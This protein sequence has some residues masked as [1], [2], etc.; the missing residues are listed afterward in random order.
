MSVRA[1]KAFD[2]TMQCRGFQFEVG[3]TY[4]HDGKVVACESGF[5]ACENPLDVWSYYPLDSRYAV[6]DLSGAVSRHDDDSKIAAARITI[7]AEID[8]PQIISDG[9]AYLMGLCNDAFALKP[10]A[11]ASGYGSKLAA[12]GYG[13]KLAASGDYS[14][15]A[16]SG[17]RSQLAA[18]GDRSVCMSAGLG[19]T[20]RAGDGGA[21]ALTYH[22]GTRYRIAVAYVGEGGIEPHVDYRVTDSGSFI[23]A[24]Y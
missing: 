4:E 6:V 2:K 16:A 7:S 11:A 14:Q 19:A 9:I 23:K 5:H 10:D 20:A 15:L 21:I 22:D 13:S 24:Q 3:Q 12:S 18:S 17:D 8:L 1:Y